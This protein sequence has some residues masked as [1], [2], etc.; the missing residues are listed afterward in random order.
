MAGLP[1]VKGAMSKVIVK[2]GR[3]VDCEQWVAEAFAMCVC[4]CQVVHTECFLL[5]V[6]LWSCL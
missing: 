4:L 3:L 6:R 2:V 5:H 1:T